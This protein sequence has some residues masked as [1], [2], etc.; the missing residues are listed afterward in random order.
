[1]PP[2]AKFQRT[3]GSDI[4]DKRFGY[5]LSPGKIVDGGSFHVENIQPERM[6]TRALSKKK[7]GFVTL[8]YRSMNIAPYEAMG[9][10]K[11][12]FSRLAGRSLI[13]EVG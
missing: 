4:C 9:K 1:L 10:R 13:G 5:L 7:Y 2:T 3:V 11:N 12:G 8:R 6:V